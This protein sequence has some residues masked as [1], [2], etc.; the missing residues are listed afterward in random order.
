MLIRFDRRNLFPRPSIVLVFLLFLRID[1]LPAPVHE[2][3]DKA[4]PAPSS[5][6]SA[7][8]KTKPKATA[9]SEESSIEGKSERQ[10]TPRPSGK[11]KNLGGPSPQYPPEAA[12]LHLSG[13]G[14]YLLHF[15]QSTGLVTDVTVVQSA[16]SPLLDEAA[17]NGFRQWHED[18]N[19]AK[20]VTMT[21]TFAS[22]GVQ[23]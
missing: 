10:S 9:K 1:R 3:D 16:G 5:E 13:V 23:Q 2:E 15:D 8:P 18:P 19:C 4:T 6:E 14:T 22:G 7:K 12:P 11:A 17:K 21:M 20:E